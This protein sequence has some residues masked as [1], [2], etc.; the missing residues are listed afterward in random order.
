M[1]ALFNLGGG[2]LLLLLSVVLLLFWT[3]IFLALRAD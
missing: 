2:E 1:L 3:K